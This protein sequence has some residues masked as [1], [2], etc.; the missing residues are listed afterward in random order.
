MEACLSLLLGASRTLFRKVLAGWVPWIFHLVLGRYASSMAEKQE[1][2]KES[3]Y[4]ESPPPAE[5]RSETEWFPDW[6]EP[7]KWL[8]ALLGVLSNLWG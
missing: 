8:E 7:S 2:P 3:P 6:G 1:R 5:E 4:R